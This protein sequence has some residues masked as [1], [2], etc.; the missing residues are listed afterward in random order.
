MTGINEKNATE[1]GY[2]DFALDHLISCVYTM[3]EM[4]VIASGSKAKE[5][6]DALLRTSERC[7]EDEIDTKLMLLSDCILIFTDAI[8]RKQDEVTDN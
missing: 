2:K 3:E 8:K 5:A 1:K 6:F 7:T 4:N